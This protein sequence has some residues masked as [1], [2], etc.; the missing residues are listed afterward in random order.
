MRG[1]Y[2]DIIRVFLAVLTVISIVSLFLLRN[3]LTKYASD[4]LIAQNTPE[5]NKKVTL[6][7]DSLFNYTRN[8]SG[9]VVTF[10]EFGSTGCSACKKMEKVMD[11]IKDLYAGKVQVVFYNIT[12]PENHEMMKYY[13]ISVIPTQVLLDNKGQEYFRH[14]GFFSAEELS[15]VINQKIISK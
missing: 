13:G 1:K 2:K 15:K 6:Q 4:T 12:F 11:E 5:L 3:K 10:L 7:A 14:T 9:F 8:N